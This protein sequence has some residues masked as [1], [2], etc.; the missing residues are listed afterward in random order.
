M[1]GAIDPHTH[2]GGGKMT[3]ARM[4]IPE[5][6]MKDEVKRAIDRVKLFTPNEYK[7]G[8]GQRVF[9]EL[10]N[11]SKDMHARSDVPFDCRPYIEPVPGKT[12]IELFASDYENL[13]VYTFTTTIY[14]EGTRCIFNPFKCRDDCKHS[15]H[16]IHQ[17]V[18]PPGTTVSTNVDDFSI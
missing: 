15:H 16:Q 4:M 7:S 3:I 8:Y 13:D 12:S 2:I 14:S 1:A 5:D 9:V 10:R 17:L 11:M 18:T 6:H